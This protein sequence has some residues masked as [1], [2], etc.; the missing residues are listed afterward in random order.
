MLK[1]ASGRALALALLAAM[2]AACAGERPVFLPPEPPRRPADASRPANA[3]DSAAQREH[4]RLMAAFGGDYSAPAAKRIVD[5]V[6][7]KLASASGQAGTRYEATLLNSPV[8][9]AFALPN[10]RLYLTRGLLALAND[11]AE[12]A[13]V[14][15]HEIAH[16]QARHAVE[17]AEMQQRSELVQRVVAQVLDDP[18][19]GAA[20]QARSKVTIASF[21][22]NQELEADLIAV[23]AIA[24]AGYD[25]YGASRFLASLG[26]TTNHRA[27][28]TGDRPGR[29][30]LDIL[31]SHPSTV[32]R[33]QMTL[34]TA[35]QIAAPGLGLSDRDAWLS[36]LDG[37]AFGD[38]PRDGAVRGR[39]YVNPSLGL[40][41]TA[42]EGLTLEST[43]DAVLGVGGNGSKA[44][45]FD[46]VQLDASQT[47]ESY[48]GTGWIEGVMPG[49]VEQITV[50]GLRAAL[51]SGKGTDWNFRL[52]AI[53]S[54]QRTYRF[55]FAA[56][57]PEAE[58]DRTF[59]A[60]VTSFQQLSASDVSRIK[61]LRLRIVT[62][63]GSDTAQ[64]L[65]SQMATDD[66]PLDQFLI[67]NGLDRGTA[68]TPGRRYKLIVE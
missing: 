58:L 20:V 17:R 59:R 65:A 50:N 28:L 61:P 26:R 9:N 49:P 67:L 51:T 55:I 11:Q 41:F 27:M 47:L 13:S 30:G 8:V 14:V 60:V 6:I 16:V 32:E 37:M 34:A 19:A 63:G 15:A 21:S 18:V 7:A 24:A 66:K 36:A 12:I 25:P 54:N 23:K 1:P 46:S 10:G 2:L 5:Q 38:D 44:M 35:R 57:G 22:R 48:V 52:A 31:S 53:Q 64:S 62:A 4:Q 29:S 40:S 43:R 3:L 42:P 45:R 39:R 56:K 68:I 33:I